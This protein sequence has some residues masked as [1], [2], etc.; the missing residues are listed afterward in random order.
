[1]LE[2]LPIGSRTIALQNRRK[3]ME[4][5][6]IRIERAIDTFSKKTVYIAI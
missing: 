2:K 5:K 3:E 4:D 6:L 1:M